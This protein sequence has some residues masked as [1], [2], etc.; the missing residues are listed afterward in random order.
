MWY[1]NLEH[2][3]HACL[4]SI[5]TLLHRDRPVL[6][7]IPTRPVATMSRKHMAA[8]P[9]LV[10]TVDGHGCD[11][12]QKDASYLW[13]LWTVPNNLY[14]KNHDSRLISTDWLHL[15]VVQMRR[16]QDLVIF[17]EATM[18]RQINLD[19]LITLE[20]ARK[21]KKMHALNGKYKSWPDTC[22]LSQWPS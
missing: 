3:P 2:I 4:T 11:G 6:L 7:T 22:R 12:Q 1:Q 9:M 5:C 10:C 8:M 18:D 21:V 19:R 16:C 17:V 20:Y 14:S 13:H 15:R